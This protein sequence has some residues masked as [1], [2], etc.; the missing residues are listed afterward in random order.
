M[1]SNHFSLFSGVLVGSIENFGQ[2]M[3]KFEQIFLYENHQTSYRSSAIFTFCVLEIVS[4]LL[5]IARTQSR[6]Y[7]KGG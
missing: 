5:K 4:K 6:V 3:V 1:K 7:V 2:K